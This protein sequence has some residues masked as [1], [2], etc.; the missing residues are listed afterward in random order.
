VAG[1][2]YSWIALDL[3]IERRR[4]PNRPA[5]GVNV[6]GSRVLTASLVCP[7][8]SK[9]RISSEGL[10]LLQFG[11]IA[12]AQLWLPIEPSVKLVA[13]TGLA[14]AIQAPGRDAIVT[15]VS[16]ELSGHEGGALVRK[17]LGA[18]EFASV[19]RAA[20]P[21]NRGES[22]PWPSWHIRHR[23]CAALS[24]MIDTLRRSR[25]LPG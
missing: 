4:T 14:R 18:H 22:P 9:G 11:Q 10:Q 6:I 3:H 7:Q 19:A 17:Q 8:R 16:N 2:L 21:L 13:A 15:L 1:A 23:T 20:T 24:S 5:S 12:D 25:S